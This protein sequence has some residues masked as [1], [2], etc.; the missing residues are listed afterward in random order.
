MAG[1]SCAFVPVAHRD[2]GGVIRKRGSWGE[3]PNVRQVLCIC[4]SCPQRDS[5]MVKHRRERAARENC[6]MSHMCL[7]YAF[8][9]LSGPESAYVAIT[10]R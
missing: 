6:Q 7:V 9:I 8:H 1:M 2:A 10:L 3:L 4:T 5:G